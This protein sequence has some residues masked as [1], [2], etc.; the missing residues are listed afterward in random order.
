SVTAIMLSQTDLDKIEVLDCSKNNWGVWSNK[1][2]NY[3][4]LKHE[5]GYILGLVT[6]PNPSL[7]PSSAGHWD[8]NNHCIV[9]ALHTCSTAEENEFLR[10]YTNA[11]LTWDALKSRHEKASSIAQILLIQQALTVKYVHSKRLSTTST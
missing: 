7:D 10:G 6:C 4:L 11:Y 1:M 5:G 3:L 9:A 2:Q 8:L